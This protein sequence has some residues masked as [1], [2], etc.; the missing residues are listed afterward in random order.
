MALVAK[1][2]KAH[3][4]RNEIVELLDWK[5]KLQQ[6]NLRH[7]RLIREKRAAEIRINTLNDVRD[8]LVKMW[9]QEK[10][11]ATCPD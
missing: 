9:I 4:L 5:I 11:R 6:T 3:D 2:K 8:D 10:V 7:A 1:S